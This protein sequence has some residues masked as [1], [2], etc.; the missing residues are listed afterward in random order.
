LQGAYL[1]D[2]EVES[3]VSFLK[4]QASPDYEGHLMEE[5]GVKG[6]PREFE[7]ELLPRA[8]EVFIEAGHGSVSLLQRRLRV[9]YARAARLIDVME[10]R[11]IIGAY[12]GNK[13][14]TVLMT[15]EQFQQTFKKE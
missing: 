6:Y 10:R 7:D 12:E 15:M 13:P 3:L 14:R 8:V 5:T 2:R 4:K 9:G 1:S 11:G